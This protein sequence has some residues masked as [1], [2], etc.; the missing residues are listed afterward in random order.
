MTRIAF[1][2]LGAMGSRM[3]TRLLAAGHALTVWNRSA[4]AADALRA[5][6]AAV[7]ASPR[8]AA[9]QAEVVFAMLFDD[10]ASRSA[11]LDAEQGAAQ[12]LA[13]GTLAV[14]TSTLSPAWTATLNTALAQRG[15]RFVDAPVAGSRP[16]AEAGQLIFLTGGSAADVEALRPLLTALGTAVHHVGPSGAGATLKLAANAL[17]ATQVAA[18]A[19]L[20]RFVERAGLD[21]PRALEALRSLPITSPAAAG[22][23]ALTLARNFQPQAP[24]ALLA[25]DLGYALDAARAAGAALP[26][27]E[28]VEALFRRAAREGLGCENL[29][30]VARLL[31]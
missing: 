22:V 1:L 10:A 26:T 24:V 4:G 9:A 13:P 5:R 17:F 3:A 8:A 18:M 21:A 2:G 30:A 16:Q 25:K 7:A 14:E 19:E 27:T 29:N 28:A 23:A 31:P 6:G 20:L 12:S 11:W 15:V